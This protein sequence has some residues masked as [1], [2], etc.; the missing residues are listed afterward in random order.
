MMRFFRRFPFYKEILA[1]YAKSFFLWHRARQSCD[2][3]TFKSWIFRWNPFKLRSRDS[4]VGVIV[5]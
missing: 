5:N 1:D 2:F 3:K 4:S